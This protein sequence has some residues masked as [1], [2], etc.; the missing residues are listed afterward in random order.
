MR[1]SFSGVLVN[2]STH[3]QNSL[4]HLPTLP[5]LPPKSPPSPKKQQKKS[6]FSSPKNDK[7]HVKA[8]DFRK[9]NSRKDKDL[10]LYHNLAIP[11]FA[12]YHPKFD[13][14]ERKPLAVFF[15]KEE[16]VT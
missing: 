13:L 12:N 15:D 2:L 9:M 16:E 6:A 8:I 1:I 5:S 7:S 3:H 11:S 4:Q 10:V 14:L